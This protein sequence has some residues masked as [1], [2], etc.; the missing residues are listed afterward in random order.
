MVGPCH[1]GLT[2]GCHD[3]RCDRCIVGGNCH[4]PDAAFDRP[5]PDMDD[6]RDP[7]NIGKWLTRQSRRLHAGGDQNERVHGADSSRQSFR[8]DRSV[9]IGLAMMATGLRGTVA[10]LPA[11]I[12]ASHHIP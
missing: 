9:T 5:V 3:G 10:K 11:D 12:A 2:T 6:H 7:A 4:P 8:R 1:Y